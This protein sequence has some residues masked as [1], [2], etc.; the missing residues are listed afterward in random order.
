MPASWRR[1]GSGLT[2]RSG[3]VAWAAAVQ[4]LTHAQVVKRA[5]LFSR[6]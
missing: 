5:F 2:G 3:A 1:R 6:K 4:P